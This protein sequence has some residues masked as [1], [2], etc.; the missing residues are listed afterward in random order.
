MSVLTTLLFYWLGT[1]SSHLWVITPA[2]L[3]E[4]PLTRSEQIDVAV[5]AYRQSF[6]EPRDPLEAGTSDGKKLYDALIAPAESLI[7]KNSRVVV[8]PDGSLNSLNFETLIATH[9]NP[10]TGL[11]T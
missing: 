10:I 8:L 5:K 11:K 4:L 6:L 9:R 2:K 1:Q 7:P 3:L